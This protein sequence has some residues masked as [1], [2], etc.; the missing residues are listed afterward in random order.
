M[1]YGMAEPIKEALVELGYRIREYCPLGEMLSGW[2]ISVRRLLENTSNEGFLRATFQRR[3]LR[4]DP[5]PRSRHHTP[6]PRP[7]TAEPEFRNEPHADFSRALN[8]AKQMRRWTS[9][10]RKDVWK[11][12][13][14]P[15]RPGQGSISGSDRLAKSCEAQT[16]SSGGSKPPIKKTSSTVGAPWPPPQ[17]RLGRIRRAMRRAEVL[18]R[19]GEL[20]RQ[21]R[22]E[23]AALGGLRDRQDMVRGGRRR[24]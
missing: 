1:L 15:P 17:L 24:L 5:S 4:G 21:P 9:R 7:R 10:S 8:F 16:K 22:F 23:L 14:P 11:F 13:R 2:P 19:A 6:Y 3:S 20:L 12:I 18:Q